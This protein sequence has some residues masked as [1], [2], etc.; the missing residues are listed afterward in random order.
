FSSKLGIYKFT[1]KPTPIPIIINR[2][3][4][5]K[6][7]NLIVPNAYRFNVITVLVIIPLSI[8][9]NTAVGIKT[10]NKRANIHGVYPNSSK[11]TTE[12]I[13][14][15]IH[16]KNRCKALSTDFFRDGWIH[17]IVK[18][19]A[20]TTLDTLNNCAIEIAIGVAIAVLI[21]L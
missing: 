12:K 4:S 1:N 2:N 7:P 17:K 21:V 8:F 3:S 20:D 18:I 19:P 5:Y 11:K 14:A 16:A 13:I 15:K 9:K 10:S 6:N